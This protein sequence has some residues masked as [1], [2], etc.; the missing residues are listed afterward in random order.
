M[1]S[2]SNGITGAQCLQIRAGRFSQRLYG[3]FS[4]LVGMNNTPG[5]HSLFPAAVKRHNR[6]LRLALSLALAGLVSACGPTI[7]YRGYVISKNRL[8]QIDVGSTREDVESTL[9]SPSTTS[10]IGGKTYYY[11]SSKVETNL[12]FAPEVIDRKILAVQFDDTDIVTNIANYGL[13][14]GVIFDFISR[15]TPT[16]GKQLTFIQQMFGNIGKFNKKAVIPGITGRGP[17]R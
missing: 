6:G 13:K 14:D 5:S 1:N 16:R 3:W 15:K 9:G 12:F 2:G 4:S 17:G 11:I 10:T 7:D 8:S